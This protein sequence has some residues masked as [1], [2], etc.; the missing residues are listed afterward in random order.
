ML[1][2]LLL[3]LAPLAP[4]GEPRP[5]APLY[6][7]LPYLLPIRAAVLAG[8]MAYQN[9]RLTLLSVVVLPVIGWAAVTGSVAPAAL[10][11]FAQRQGWLQR[12]GAR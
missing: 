7:V 5:L 8:V 10:Y 2:S 4:A 1:A 6:E 3:T 9:W 12:G 11:L